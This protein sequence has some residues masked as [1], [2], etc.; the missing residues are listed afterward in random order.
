MELK[1]I[2][3]VIKAALWL[4][5]LT[6]KEVTV[7]LMIVSCKVIQN[8]ILRFLCDLWCTMICLVKKLK[9]RFK[10]LDLILD[11]LKETYPKVQ[12]QTM[13]TSSVGTRSLTNFLPFTYTSTLFCLQNELRHYLTLIL[14]N[15]AE[16]RLILSRRGRRPSRLKS[17]DIPQ[18]WA[19]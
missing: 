7:I 5:L 6:L 3:G 8:G 10:I 11:F 12:I 18:D 4:C 15:R 1:Y 9:I 16:Y 17:G 13:R 19:G 14:R 2:V